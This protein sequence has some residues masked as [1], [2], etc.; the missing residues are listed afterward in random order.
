MCRISGVAVIPAVGA[1]IRLDVVSTQPRE[2]FVNIISPPR[3]AQRQRIRL[4]PPDAAASL[5]KGFLLRGAPSQHPCQ[6]R[7]F[8]PKACGDKVC[9]FPAT[10]P[11]SKASTNA[12]HKKLSTTQSKPYR[13]C[14]K[15]AWSVPSTSDGHMKACAIRASPMEMSDAAAGT[16]GTLCSDLEGPVAYAAFASA[17]RITSWSEALLAQGTIARVEARRGHPGSSVFESCSPRRAILVPV[18]HPRRHTT[19]YAMRGRIL[20]W[21]A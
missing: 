11:A 21:P 20:A 1:W 14:I 10:A 3:I 7:L 16:P 12:L 6:T 4:Q 8:F 9:I 17:L 2:T 19:L 13:T 18:V 5:S 15:A